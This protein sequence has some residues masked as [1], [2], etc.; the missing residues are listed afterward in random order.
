MRIIKEWNKQHW[1]F[2]MFFHNNRYT[3]KVENG[4]TEQVYKLWD[5]SDN[6]SDILSEA[7][8]TPHIA[9]KIQDIFQSQQSLKN[10]LQGSIQTCNDIEDE[11]DEIL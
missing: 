11:F 7:T 10:E 4:S 3:M 9:Q 1:K 6:P 2:T 8:L 5:L